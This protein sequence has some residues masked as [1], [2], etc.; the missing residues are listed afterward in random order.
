MHLADTGLAL[1]P[2]LAQVQVVIVP[3]TPKK[4]EDN[5]KAA[6]EN[7]IENLVTQMKKGLRVK[8]DDRYC[9]RL[10]AKCFEQERKGGK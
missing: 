4:L 6:L 9:M 1:I 5:K 2:K 3:I 7:A 10:S 8:V